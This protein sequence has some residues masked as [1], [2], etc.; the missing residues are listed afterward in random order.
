MHVADLNLQPLQMSSTLQHKAPTLNHIV[1]VA[2]GPKTKT[3][4]SG[5]TFQGLRYYLQ[6]AKDKG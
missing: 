3:F 4:L 5:M 1:H 6:E 2:Q